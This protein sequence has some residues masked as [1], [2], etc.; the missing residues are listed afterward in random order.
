V[1]SPATL[2]GYSSVGFPS[3]VVPMG[4]GSQ[5][6]PMAVGFLG[7]PHAEGALIGYAFDYEQATTMR[8]PSPLA[9]PLPGE[10]IEY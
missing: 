10:T 4:F 8:R 9:P 6:L 7:R 2:A 5:G 1:R 3:I